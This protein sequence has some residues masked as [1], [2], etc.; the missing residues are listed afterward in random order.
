MIRLVRTSSENRDFIQ[1]V[2]RL[3]NL[4]ADLD[5]REHDFY[6]EFNRLDKIKHVVLAYDG[7]TAV[8]CGAIK[9][10][11]S[12]TTEV[13]RMFTTES[14]RG[15]GIATQILTELENWTRELGYSKCVLETGKRL[16]DAVMLYKKNAYRQIPNYRQYI[17]VE[18]S[19]CFEKILTE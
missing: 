4:L 12:E 2:A 17:H 9:E 13:K 14:Q 16:S 6:D 1:L 18:N 5:G 3:D 11:D 15:R 10:F 7:D 19:M 8:S